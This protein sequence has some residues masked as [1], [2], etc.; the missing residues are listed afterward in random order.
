MPDGI[1]QFP[2][3]LASTR[4]WVELNLDGSQ[5]PVDAA[6]QECQG[7]K[8]TQKVIEIYEVTSQPW[9]KSANTG[10]IVQTKIPGN[11][12]STNLI[13]RRGLTSSMTF[14]NWFKDVESG[15]WA[16]RRQKDG[17]LTIYDL[18]NEGI[19]KFQFQRAWPVSY[20]IGDVGISKAETEIEEVELAVESFLRVQ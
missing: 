15:N 5:Y 17:T 10:R 2:E 13:L 1:P 18:K 4:F 14:W 19:V 16:Q 6:F 11:V 9:G 20:K 3:I 7:F 12:E 8:R